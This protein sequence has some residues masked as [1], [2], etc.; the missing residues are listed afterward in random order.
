M[1]EVYVGSAERREQQLRAE[2]GP[3]KHPRSIHLA[4][5]APVYYMYSHLANT[6]RKACHSERAHAKLNMMKRVMRHF[7]VLG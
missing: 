2:P 3:A 5:W 1:N 6:D 7:H 4:L